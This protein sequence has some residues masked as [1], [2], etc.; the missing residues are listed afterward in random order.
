MYN[1]FFIQ[2]IR[3]NGHSDTPLSSH[4]FLEGGEYTAMIPRYSR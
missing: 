2:V 3:S 1:P 4:L